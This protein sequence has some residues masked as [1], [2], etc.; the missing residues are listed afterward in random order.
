MRVVV[1]TLDV[2]LTSQEDVHIERDKDDKTHFL[3]Q[4]VDLFATYY[5][6]LM[7]LM[8]FYTQNCV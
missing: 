5:L 7:I 8:T 2:L 1:R 3:M 6:V 4:N